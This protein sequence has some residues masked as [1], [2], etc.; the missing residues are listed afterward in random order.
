MNQNEEA[1]DQEYQQDHRHRHRLTQEVRESPRHRLDLVV[2]IDM[3]VGI[4]V[5]P[6][7]W[8]NCG[9]M[10]EESPIKL[11]LSRSWECKGVLKAVDQFLEATF[12]QTVEQCAL[13]TEVGFQVVPHRLGGF[14]AASNIS[15]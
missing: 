1:K 8:M 15:L 7:I 5:P 4:S 9:S 2:V 13:C 14:S 3:A 11:I 10:C 6:R 12:N